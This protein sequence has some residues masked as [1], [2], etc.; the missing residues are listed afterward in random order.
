MGAEIA[1]LRKQAEER[2]IAKE[3]AERSSASEVV[4][5]PRSDFR[6]THESLDVAALEKWSFLGEQGLVPGSTSSV[7]SA[8]KSLGEKSLGANTSV[9]MSVRSHRKS[10]KSVKS[11]RG[12]PRG[13]GG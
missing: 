11:G 7:G 13:G 3:E 4:F 10:P 12:I 5:A 2:R 8:R 1:T 6:Q 9:S